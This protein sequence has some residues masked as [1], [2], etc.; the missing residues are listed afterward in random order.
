MNDHT[1]AAAERIRAFL[2]ARDKW[3]AGLK[4]VPKHIARYPLHPASDTIVELLPD[5]LRLV[6][7]ALDDTPRYIP[8]ERGL[9]YL[10][11]RREQ[12]PRDHD[13]TKP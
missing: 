1:Q 9:N 5:D 13:T 11:N 12:H 3:N 6:L 2:D 7:A 10:A 8:T 4:R